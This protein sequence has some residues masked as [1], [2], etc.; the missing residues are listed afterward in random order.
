MNRFK[1]FSLV[2]LGFGLL[3][4]LAS[5]GQAQD[6][7][8]KQK[9]RE[10][11]QE[12]ANK[13]L[14]WLKNTQHKQDG[15]WSANGQN[16]ISMT[17]MAGLA[18]LC[19]GSTVNQGKYRDNIRRAADFLMKK[20]NKA[21][22]TNGLIGNPQ[23]AGETG[24]YM[25][26]HGFATL[27]L[28]C[29]YGEEEDKERRAELKDILTRAVLYCGS[30]QST[31][32]G[33]F[34]TAKGDP[35]GSDNDE[36][37]V[38]VTQ[39]QALRACRDAG[40]PVPKEIMKKGADYLRKSTTP[41]GGVVYSL[42]RG[43]FG[44]PAGGGRPALTAAAIACLFSA[45]DYKDEYV[46]KWFGFC[47]S[48][49]GVP[50]TGGGQFRGF[51]EYTH[52]YYAPSIY[53]IGEE[54]YGKMFPNEP[55]ANHLTWSR[56]RETYFKQLINAQSGDGS[57]QGAGGWGSGP[58]YTTAVYCVIMQLDNNCLPVFQR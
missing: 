49:R 42:G 36:G 32:G 50:L 7:A 29:V 35:P 28:A 11:Q 3:G 34:Y 2:A 43:G 44:A 4:F 38:T 25:Y 58:I 24:R 22:G 8:E 15:S 48:P 46:K 27:F 17:G 20:S 40:I 5:Q 54:G 37:S 6:A 51:D 55:K 12:A 30:A 18:L 45:G 39:M 14:D 53:F 47:N 56:Y 21:P 13:G 33:W 52:F 41:D 10:R 57:W 19:E 16:P 9:Q 1:R 23:L 26:G 31:H